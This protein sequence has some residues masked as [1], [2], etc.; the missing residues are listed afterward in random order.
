MSPSPDT[1]SSGDEAA[2]FC[3]TLAD[4]WVRLGIRHAVLAPG[5]RSTPL[6]VALLRRP[7][8]EVHVF[9]DERS[10]SFAALGIG[11]ASGR[12][13][14]LLCTSGTAAAQ[15]HAAVVEAHLADVPLLV[16]T[17]DRP[18][19]A[20]DVGAPQTIDQL[21]LFGTSVRWFHDPGVPTLAA[22]S[23]WRSLAA[24][25]VAA[26]TGTRPGPVHL[27]L[28]FREPL[29]GSPVHVPPSREGAWMRD[30]TGAGADE[31]SCAEAAALLA[32]GRTVVVAGAG[33]SPAVLDAARR[34]GWTV[35]ADPASCLRTG[36]PGVICAFDPVLRTAPP[37]ATAVLRVGDPPA[38]KVLAQ[39]VDSLGVPV[40]Q[41]TGSGRLVDPSHR[42]SL[43]LHGD[44]G[45]IVDDVAAR[46]APDDEAWSAWW[47]E[48]EAAARTVIDGWAR[49]RHGE[50]SVATH[51]A[52]ALRPGSRLVL[53]SSMPIRD[54]EWFGGHMPGVT[55]HANRGA[56]GIDG[57]VSTAVGVALAT[58]AP[59]TLLIGDVACL[60]D[61]NGL[62]GL[63]RRGLDMDIVVVN[64]DGGAIFSFLPQRGA[65]DD[66]EFETLW[67]TPHG[68]SFAA[69]SAAHGIEHVAVG[70][71]GDLP[72]VLGPRGVRLL[73]VRTDRASNT[74]EHDALNAAIAAALPPPL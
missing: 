67:G 50:P 13:A 47:R 62:L 26:A 59:T 2:S 31:G 38:S 8:I 27:N 24:R 36:D 64:N 17:A 43:H 74:S 72:G 44:V 68:V 54:M 32:G 42:V 10:A 40:V 30:T 14:V 21:N 33:A 4:E 61:T 71:A 7:G 51:V 48:A 35:F 16:C 29:L 41:V 19:E 66:V 12:P 63:A 25:S 9:H 11:R 73:E 39:W 37:A 49:S 5:S 18:P 23:S 52:A 56:N 65:T 55:V 45:A 3:A 1:P 20:R 70:A 6:A 69:L 22:S 46:V 60:H 58:A 57:V 34:V 53:S 15:F 28:P